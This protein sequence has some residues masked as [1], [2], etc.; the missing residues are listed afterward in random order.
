M[1]EEQ[2]VKKKNMKKTKSCQYNI[3]K[4]QLTGNHDGSLSQYN[5]KRRIIIF[6]KGQ[7]ED[8]ILKS[9]E[10]CSLLLTPDKKMLFTGYKNGYLQQ[11]T[12]KKNFTQ[13]KDYGRIHDDEVNPMKMTPDDK[14]LFTASINILK[15]WSYNKDKYELTNTFDFGQTTVCFQINFLFFIIYYK[16]NII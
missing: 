14:Y 13:V 4:Y 11:Y 5:I 8:C 15:Q 6:N 2:I 9:Q 16:S 7:S 12:F 1:K 10:I 3:G